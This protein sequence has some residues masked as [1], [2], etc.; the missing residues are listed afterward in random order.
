MY[1]DSELNQLD[2][3]GISREKISEQT[4]ANGYRPCFVKTPVIKA[5][6]HF[7]AQN[8]RQEITECHAFNDGREHSY[9]P[10]I[11][12]SALVLLEIVR[13]ELDLLKEDHV[14]QLNAWSKVAEM[15]TADMM[16]FLNDLDPVAIVS[17]QGYFLE[18]AIA[19][20]IGA[21][22]GVQSI[23]LENTF[24]PDRMIVEPISGLAVNKTSA[25][26]YFDHAQSHKTTQAASS[27]FAAY[28]DSID[29]SKVSDHQSPKRDYEW[30][31]SRNRI[32]FLAQCYTDSSVIYGLQND[33][34][35]IDIM[36]ELINY[37][38][39]YDA[40]LVIKLHPKENGG[41]N[42]LGIKYNKVTY[43]KLISALSQLK[44]DPDAAK[45]IFIDHDNSVSTRSL[46]ESADVITTIN[47]QAGFESL[48]RGK[49]VV[50]LG[51]SFFSSLGC[52]WNIS[53]LAQLEPTL[54]L[55][56][57]NGASLND[58]TVVTNFADTYI[59]HYCVEKSAPSMVTAI[60]SRIVGPSFHG[61]HILQA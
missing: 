9:C 42:P 11:E 31:N 44:M 60:S 12:Y 52:T 55:V 34:T 29:K 57:E 61:P 20:K 49:E 7:I 2:W 27:D 50:L 37:A 4:E 59:N 14:F 5:Y 35:P 26:L 24:I 28:L 48:I 39:K 30:S 51:Y 13:Q 47:S 54:K 58:K 17:M 56:L 22:K 38:A 43:R 41:T 8:A 15:I 18:S 25:N 6:N 33:Y 19:K 16:N 23:A 21:P 3:L 32:V 53:H 1:L 36:L 40:E 10:S 45:R 46:I